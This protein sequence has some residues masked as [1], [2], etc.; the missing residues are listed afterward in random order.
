MGDAKAAGLVVSSCWLVDGYIEKYIA[1]NTCIRSQSA[2][3]SSCPGPIQPVEVDCI[4]GSFGS[5]GGS[6]VR[7]SVGPAIGS[8]VES[9]FCARI[10]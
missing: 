9:S 6:F 5:S 3:H 8:S 10:R 7:T 4:P 1:S 2:S